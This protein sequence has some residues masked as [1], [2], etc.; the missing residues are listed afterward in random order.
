MAAGYAVVWFGTIASASPTLDILPPAGQEWEIHVMWHGADGKLK[1][2]DGTSWIA[3][4][5]TGEGT[6]EQLKYSITDAFYLQLENTSGADAH[7]GY[8]GVVTKG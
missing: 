3:L 5:L 1:F 2:G 6:E 4:E 7:F 8:M